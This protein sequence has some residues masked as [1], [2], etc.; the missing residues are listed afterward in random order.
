MWKNV[1]KTQSQ[2]KKKGKKEEGKDESRG[3]L[4]IPNLRDRGKS[5]YFLYV[6]LKKIRKRNTPKY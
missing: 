1:Y 5:L 4:N 6:E 3:N 2:K